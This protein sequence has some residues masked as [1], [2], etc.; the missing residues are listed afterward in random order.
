[1]KDRRVGEQTAK[2]EQDALVKEAERQQAIRIAQL[3]RDQKVGEQQAAF[4]RESKLAE[5]DRDKRVRLADANAQAVA[6]ESTAQADIASAQATLAVKRA[7]AYQISETKKREAEASVLEAQNRAMAKAALADAEKIE[8]EKRA[9]LEAPAKAEKARIIV[10]AQA[11]AEQTK[12]AAEAQAAAIY[13]KLE[14]EARGQYEILAKKG[15]GLR[16]IIEACG[17]AQAA[18][19]MLMLEHMDAL[20]QASAKAI[21]N[22]KF[23]KVVVWEGGGGNTGTSN[24]AAFLKDLARMMPPMMQVMKDVG[25]VEMPEYFARL[26]PESAAEGKHG[27]GSAKPAVNGTAAG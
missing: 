25:G 2:F 17:G 19:Q 7:E 21:S 6:G 22:I 12:L 10:E 11:A 1:D 3:D 13:A 27:V 23:D 20:A 18:F 4:E 16:T 26:V 5:A 15:V 8:A 14:A 9:E 24:T